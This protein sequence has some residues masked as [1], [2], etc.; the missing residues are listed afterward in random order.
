MSLAA[1]LRP[2]KK[3]AAIDLALSIVWVGLFFLV[4]GLGIQKELPGFDLVGMV[5][6]FFLNIVVLAGFFHPAVC[7]ALYFFERPETKNNKKNSDAYASL[8]FL[9][10]LNP[11]SLTL[12][13]SGYVYFNNNVTSVPCGLDVTGFPADSPAF[14]S[15]IKEGDV[16]TSLDGSKIDTLDSFFKALS[17]KKPGDNV[18]VETQRGAFAVR[19]MENPENHKTVLGVSVKQRYCRR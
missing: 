7:G 18:S 12:L 16:I 11:V 2:T 5:G 19:L 3:K 14:A 1:L 13:Y 6:V 17:G 9:A 8:F 10:V 4:P 15:G